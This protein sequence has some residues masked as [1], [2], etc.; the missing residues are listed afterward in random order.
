MKKSDFVLSVEE[1]SLVISIVGRPEVAHGLMAAQLGDMQEEE[2]RARLLAAGHSLMARGWLTMDS[3][4]T[5]R[6]ADPLARI[7]RILS[8]ADFSVRYSSTRCT[9][10]RLDHSRTLSLSGIP[11][12]HR[13]D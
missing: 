5:M 4:A 2:A 10:P 1:V 13:C 6:L 12:S 11:D 3:Q 9:S 8:R 7:A